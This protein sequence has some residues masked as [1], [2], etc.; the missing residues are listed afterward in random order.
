LKGNPINSITSIRLEALEPSDLPRIL[1]WIDPD[2]FRI[3]RAP[4]DE[5]QLKQLLSSYKDEKPISLGYR[6]VRSSDSALVGMIHA[7]VVWDNNL[8][9]IG[10]IVV[11]DPDLRDSGIGT[12]S[13]KLFLKICFDD[14]NLHRV[15]LFVDDDNY[16]AIAC[17]KKAGF[18]IEGLMREATKTSSGY[19]SWYSMSI[20]EDEWRD[21]ETGRSS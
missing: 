3:F 11:G 6:I 17:Y 21:P 10:Q 2:V 16:G 14:L 7:T 5:E 1:P 9:H 19:I 8:A 20:L 13:L 4:V 15:Q 18:Q 12:E